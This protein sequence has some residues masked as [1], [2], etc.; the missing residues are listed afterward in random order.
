MKANLAKISH[1]AVKGEE[2]H[3]HHA[4]VFKFSNLN[5]DEEIKLKIESVRIMH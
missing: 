4:A 5:Y 1:F 3:L 2:V